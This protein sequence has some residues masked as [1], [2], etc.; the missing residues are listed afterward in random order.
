MKTRPKWVSSVLSNLDVVV[1][2]GYIRF[3]PKVVSTLRPTFKML[4]FWRGHSMMVLLLGCLLGTVPGCSTVTQQQP[5]H[6][7]GIVEFQF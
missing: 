5:Q 7:R 1:H 6:S 4:R 3:W 2:H